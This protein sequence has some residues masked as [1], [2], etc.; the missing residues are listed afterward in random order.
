MMKTW[1]AK[2]GEAETP[3]RFGET[4]PGAAKVTYRPAKLTAT[5][6]RRALKKR[7]GKLDLVAHMK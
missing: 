2:C 7:P 6:K 1:P 5:M 3:A 4:P